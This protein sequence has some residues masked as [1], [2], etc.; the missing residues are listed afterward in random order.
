MILETGDYKLFIDEDLTKQNYEN[1]SINDTIVKLHIPQAVID[2]LNDLH[3]DYL[4]PQSIYYYKT[5]GILDFYRGVYSLDGYM[6]QGPQAFTLANVENGIETY[7]FTGQIIDAHEH[8][9][10]FINEESP[11]QI[12]LEFN[13]IVQRNK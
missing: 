8:F 3:I 7:D 1:L 12:F 11:D 10:Y 5:E 2:Y 6:L 9:Q 13:L 4:K